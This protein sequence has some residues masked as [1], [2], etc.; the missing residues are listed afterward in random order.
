MPNDFPLNSN[1]AFENS[2]CQSDDS[3]PANKQWAKPT[4]TLPTLVSFRAGHSPNTT[5]MEHFPFEMEYN[6]VLELTECLDSPIKAAI[7]KKI[8][9]DVFAQMKMKSAPILE[10]RRKKVIKAEDKKFL[11]LLSAQNYSK[12]FKDELESQPKNQGVRQI[13]ESQLIKKIRKSAILRKIQNFWDHKSPHY[14]VVFKKLQKL[15]TEDRSQWYE[16]HDLTK[17][18]F[19]LGT[20]EIDPIMDFSFSG[21]NN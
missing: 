11:Q 18:Q 21:T 19:A 14:P 10:F 1:E 12:D 3:H 16:F 5:S 20:D 13:E 4:K 7:P 6:K 17:V 8:F 9:D 15:A 2:F